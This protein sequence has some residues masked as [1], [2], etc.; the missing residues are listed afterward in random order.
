MLNYVALYS[1]TL[2]ACST[3]F[4]TAS[5]RPYT[6]EQGMN[7]DSR[8]SSSALYISLVPIVVTY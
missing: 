7:Y 3:L 1:L 4:L 5:N 2:L 8:S 6:V